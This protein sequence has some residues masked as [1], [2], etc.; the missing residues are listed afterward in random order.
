[1]LVKGI[2]HVVLKVRNL[3]ASD[4]FYRELVGLK[5]VGNRG[6]MRF[7]SAGTH[8]H[9]FAIMEVGADAPTPSRATGLFHFCFD[10]ANEEDLR[11]LYARLKKAGVSVSGGVDHNIMHS[12]YTHDPDGHVVEFG[13]DVPEKDWVGPDP[14]AD[15]KSFDL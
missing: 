14:W 15:D 13:V 3:E 1:M 12:F 9:D 11:Q 2:N 4:R 7:Y 8:A 5:V 6:R 10:V